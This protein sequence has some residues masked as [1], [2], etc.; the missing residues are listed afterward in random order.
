MGKP[1]S[2]IE[3]KEIII[4][5]TTGAG[6]N[7][8][9]ANESDTQIFTNNILLGATLT[10]IGIF[11]LFYI[12]KKYKKSQHEWMRKTIREEFVR[13]LQLRLS[14]RGQQ[15]ATDEEQG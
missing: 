4:A 14:G 1:Y 6:K 15:Q 10:I 2:K 7:S 11:I 9:S 8:A 5:Q 12:Y 13:R 3:D